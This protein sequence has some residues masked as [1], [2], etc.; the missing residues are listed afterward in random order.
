MTDVIANEYA[1]ILK[2]LETQ[3]RLHTIAFKIWT[4]FFGFQAASSLDAIL[5]YTADRSGP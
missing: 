5:S 4:A 2:L 1:N 3:M